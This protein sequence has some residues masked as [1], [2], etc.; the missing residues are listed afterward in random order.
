MKVLGGLSTSVSVSLPVAVGVLAVAFET[1]PASTAEPAAVPETIAASLTPLIL[2]VKSRL[3]ESVPSDTVIVK[4]SVVG[5]CS[6]LIA[7]LFG[8]KV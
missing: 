8:T 4:L 7:P 5:A 3:V 6:A 1:P 2:M